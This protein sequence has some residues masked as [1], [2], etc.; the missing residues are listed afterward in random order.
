MEIN[1]TYSLALKHART[2]VAVGTEKSTD[3]RLFKEYM[4][5]M[6]RCGDFT[7]LFCVPVAE[8]IDKNDKGERG[9]ALDSQEDKG[10]MT[11][12]SPYP[13]LLQLQF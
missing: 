5:W 11:L 7:A 3:K 4:H 12:W 9:D 6:W 13:K 8:K 1:T 2:K 10:I